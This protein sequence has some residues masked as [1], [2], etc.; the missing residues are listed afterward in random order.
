MTGGDPEPVSGTGVSSA[1][2]SV[3]GNRMVYRQASYGTYDIWRIPGPGQSTTDRT[4]ERLISS[5]GLDGAPAFSLDGGQVAFS[6]TRSGVD[7]VWRVQS[8]GSRPTQLTNFKTSSGTPAWSPDGGRIVFDSLESGSYDL[9]VVDAE[10][11]VPRQ[12]TFEPSEA[13]SPSW[14]RDGR[15]I[16]FH[17][18]R[19]GAEQIW[20]IPADGGEAVQI[21]QE[22]GFY[23]RESWDGRTLYYANSH[24]PTGVWKVP[25]DGGEEI[26]IVPEIIP[27]FWGWDLSQ[28]GIYYLTGPAEELPGPRFILG[29]RTDFTLHFLDLATGEVS[30]LFRRE[31]VSLLRGLAVSPDEKWILYTEISAGT[32]E[33]ILIENFR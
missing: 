2:V 14:S 26:E 17:S 33:L 22:G 18:D 24:G 9:W 25:V 12:L 8:D 1:Y 15:W 30:D 23:A 28:S 16:Y 29:V 27:E 4:P 19:G 3:R 7:Q 11:G 21:T 13:G 6:S 5:S 20:K 32:A 10:G 31:G